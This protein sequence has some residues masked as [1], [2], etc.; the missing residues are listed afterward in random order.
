VVLSKGTSDEVAGGASEEV[1][2]GA[3]LLALL[4]PSPVSST[5][6]PRRPEAPV[7]VGDVGSI[8]RE[9]VQLLPQGI[10]VM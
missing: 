9:S 3:D 2:D 10:A 1:D 6:E 5:P 7:T 4:A 8:C